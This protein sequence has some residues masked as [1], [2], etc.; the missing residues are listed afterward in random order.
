MSWSP[1]VTSGQV[2]SYSNRTK[3]P[4]PVLAIPRSFM[5]FPDSLHPLDV[6]VMVH[7]HNISNV[8]LKV[9]FE[10]L[11]IKHSIPLF[12]YFNEILNK[13]QCLSPILCACVYSELISITMNVDLANILQLEGGVT[14]NDFKDK[15]WTRRIKI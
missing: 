13:S 5:E 11:P 10:N 2:F 4:T 9:P 15:F 12:T 14:Q 8:L 1:V 3:N 7:Q 6:L